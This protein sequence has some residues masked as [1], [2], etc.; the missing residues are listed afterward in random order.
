MIEYV[1]YNTADGASQAPVR[2]KVAGDKY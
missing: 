1:K 2:W